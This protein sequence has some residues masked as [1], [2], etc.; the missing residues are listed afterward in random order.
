[1]FS[2][3]IKGVPFYLVDLGG[4]AA[5]YIMLSESLTKAEGYRAFNIPGA[6]FFIH[7]PPLFPILLS[8]IVAFLGRNFIFLHG[9]IFLLGFLSLILLYYLLSE[10]KIDITAF[11]T[12]ILFALNFHFIHFSTQRVLSEI[13]YLFFSLLAIIISNNYLRKEE[14]VF[15]SAGFFTIISLLLVY[16]TRYIGI[17]LIAGICFVLLLR[18]EYKKFFF[19]ASG[20]GLF[21]ILWHGVYGRLLVRTLFS[22]H[23][24]NLLAINYYNLEQGTLLEHPEYILVRVWDELKN[25]YIYGLSASFPFLIKYI[26]MIANN[27]WLFFLFFWLVII[28]SAA[29]KYKKQKN[30]II[31]FYLIFYISMLL[32]LNMKGEAIRYLLPL[33]PFFIYFFLVALINIGYIF[34]K[35][36]IK[37]FVFFIIFILFILAGLH[38]YHNFKRP[39]YS[40]MPKVARDFIELHYWVKENIPKT[41][42]IV[43]RKP[44]FTY[45]YSDHPSIGYPFTKDNQAIYQFMKEKGLCYLLFDGFYNETREYLIPF[46]RKYKDKFIILYHQSRAAVLKINDVWCK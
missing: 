45:F 5:Q 1:M 9:L 31:I 16:L 46:L 12:V 10:R 43:F 25:Y 22:I 32:L 38:D 44:T 41:E 35:K 36:I 18:R 14:K 40:E 30:Q 23:A 20:I 26:L 17:T 19:L 13:P 4:D 39:I 6:P 11:L 27:K 42:I 15:S 21:L 29:F 7:Y 33:V 3:F 2:F 24:H 8:V 34:Q 28:I 37:Y